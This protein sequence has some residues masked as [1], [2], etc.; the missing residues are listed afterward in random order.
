MREFRSLVKIFW[1]KS[2][3][4]FGAVESG[5][6]TKKAG[7]GRLIKKKILQQQLGLVYRQAIFV[8]SNP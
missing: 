5:L 8:K 6:K 1:N 7:W 3:Q 4:G 2:L